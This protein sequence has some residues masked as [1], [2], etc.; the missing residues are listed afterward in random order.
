MT[1]MRT[2]TERIGTYHRMMN[3]T[4]DE[5]GGERATVFPAAS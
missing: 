1:R 3:E 4:N 5:R 2:T